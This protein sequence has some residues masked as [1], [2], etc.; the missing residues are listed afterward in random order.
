MGKIRPNRSQ[1]KDISLGVKILHAVSSFDMGQA[2]VVSEG[3]IIGIE[4]MEGTDQLLKR[5]GSMRNRKKGG[6]LVKIPKIGQDRSL[7]LPSIGIQ[8]IRETARA[9]IRGIA[10]EQEGALIDSSR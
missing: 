3:I 4:A 7:D 10:V 2:A 1:K 6:V 5:A 9:D 8:T